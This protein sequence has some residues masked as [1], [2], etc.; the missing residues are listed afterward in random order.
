MSDSKVTSAAV[1]NR[2]MPARFKRAAYRLLGLIAMPCVLA[3]S[4]LAAAPNPTVSG[5]IASPAIPGDV[6]HDYT[7]FATTHDLGTR[8]YVEEE[9]FFDGTANRYTTPPLA[10]ATIQDSGHPYRTRMVVRR[11]AASQESE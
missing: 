1:R 3:T 5:P 4:A 9:F 11:P 8:G 7:F 2:P 10:T 6:S